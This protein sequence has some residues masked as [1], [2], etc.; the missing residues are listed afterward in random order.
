MDKELAEMMA[1]VVADLEAEAGE[2]SEY[3]KALVTKAYIRGRRD[4]NR[5]AM[6]ALT[7]HDS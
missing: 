1:P 7:R 6:E 3:E 4:E 5:E 2:L